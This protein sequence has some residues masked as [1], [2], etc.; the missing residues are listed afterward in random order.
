MEPIQASSTM[1]RGASPTPPM[2]TTPG[3]HVSPRLP[4]WHLPYPAGSGPHWST[5][6]ASGM[7]QKAVDVACRQMG[8]MRGS[9]L[10]GMYMQ[11]MQV[12]GGLGA[13]QSCHR[14]YAVQD[15]CRGR[16]PL[17]RV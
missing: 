14:V 16:E 13:V 9:R 4:P 6:C 12:G 1:Q 8:F 11:F 2:Y 10:T 7:D 17:G 3:T 15:S 5:I